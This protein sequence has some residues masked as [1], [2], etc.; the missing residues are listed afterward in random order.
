MRSGALAFLLFFAAGLT[1]IGNAVVAAPMAGPT[2]VRIVAAEE[3]SNHPI[4]RAHVTIESDN[5]SYDGYTDKAGGVT[6][7]NVPSGEYHIT[8]Q[9]PDFRFNDRVLIVG[10]SSE[11][12]RIFGTR[13]RPKLI[14]SVQSRNAPS[15]KSARRTSGDVQ[16][17]ISGSVGAA[18]P[19][20]PSVDASN[21]SIFIHGHE[22]S[23]TSTTLNGAAIFPNDSGAQLGLLGSDSFQSGEVGPGTIAGGPDGTL[24]LRTYDPT[25]DW[26]GLLQTRVATFGSTSYGFQA[27]GTSGRLG[28]SYVHSN[29]SLADAL[30]GAY[31]S[32]LSGAYYQH[33]T[34]A[35][36][37]GDTATLRYGLD[38]NNVTW[39]DV[40]NLSSDASPRCRTF[41]A[42]LPCGFGP[43]NTSAESVRY[44]QLRDQLTLD[45]LSLDVHLF[46][47]RERRTFDYGAER[48]FNKPIGFKSETETSRIGFSATAGYLVTPKR[49]IS[50]TASGSTDRSTSNGVQ[51]NAE[52]QYPPS[53]NVLGSVRVDVPLAET[54]KASFST[55]L[56][57]ERSGTASGAFWGLNGTY[58]LTSLDDARISFSSGRLG[59]P[60]FASGLSSPETLVYDCRGRRALGYGPGDSTSGGAK[61]E[62]YGLTFT[63]RG[64]RTSGAVQ[65]FSDVDHSGQ[66]NAIVPGT[67]LPGAFPAGYAAA[68]QSDGN[69]ACG[70]GTNLGL[71]DVFYQVRGA[72]DRTVTSG[73]DFSVTSQLGNRAQIDLQYSLLYARPY[74]LSPIL[75]LDPAIREGALIP[76]I[77]AHKAS[78]SI[79][80][81][82]SRAM[83]LLAAVNYVGANN[84]N[85]RTGFSTIEVGT[86]LR[87]ASGDFVIGVQ[88]LFDTGAERFSRFTPFPYLSQPVA[89]RT[90]SFHYRLALGQQNIDKTQP[91]SAPLSPNSSQIVF[92]ANPLEKASPDALSPQ[93][94]TRF[95]GPENLPAAKTILDAITS[96]RDYV[97]GRIRDRAA[98]TIEPRRTANVDLSYIP[99]AGSYAIRISLPHTVKAAGPFLRCAQ[100]HMGDY[101][102]AKQMKLFMPGW[103]ER[104]ND[105]IWVIYYAP[106]VGLYFPPGGVDETASMSAKERPFPDTRPLADIH[107]DSTT[108]PNTYQ[109][110]AE[111]ALIDLKAYIEAYYAGRH[112]NAPQ[113]FQIASHT[114]KNGPWL[115]FRSDDFDFNDVLATCVDAPAAGASQLRSRGIS[116]AVFPSLNYAPGVGFY[117][118]DLSHAIKF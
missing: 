77:P 21:S 38:A 113:G 73:A 28:M 11:F 51:G 71:G 23:S 6:F 60:I 115:E 36:S 87:A 18:L 1:S 75:K 59:Q 26:Q 15:S 100:L 40:G 27:T 117:K 94:K 102:T 70:S 61:T 32:D 98:D 48:F 72:A 13:S 118:A 69:L 62:Q 17:K 46:Q 85:Q 45:R 107:I 35:N 55:S 65:I 82:A 86:R 49:L 68:L 7:S 105:A 81:A 64:F 89:P 90:F 83:T 29:V 53:T 114:S 80:Y 104:Y 78:A 42:T 96:Y 93:T 5:R 76:G 106:Q 52:Y 58:R 63:H 110:A 99:V 84:A 111:S 37:T 14:A 112:P 91:L 2:S 79:R 95:C 97:D 103:R 74:G 8:V 57:M 47:S 16:S 24:A 20:L 43:G 31:Y 33:R 92:A 39:L 50:F 3:V 54:R 109:S 41:T 116:G 67:G 12:A 34:I 19:S 22:S 44:V 9:Q 88:N 56:G 30:E 101:A 108:C 25:I 4:P 66:V 10:S